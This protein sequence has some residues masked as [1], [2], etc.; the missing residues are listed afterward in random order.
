[1]TDGTTGPSKTFDDHLS[2]STKRMEGDTSTPMRHERRGGPLNIPARLL[3]KPAEEIPRRRG[4]T[5]VLGD[6]ER[7]EL[8][9]IVA[10]ERLIVD[11]RRKSMFVASSA[12][13]L[14]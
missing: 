8:A 1:M 6:D 13:L 2:T 4:K 7:L 3:A 10:E 9:R 14:T 11:W 12:P 5:T